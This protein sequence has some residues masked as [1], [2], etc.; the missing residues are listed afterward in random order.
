MGTFRSR[1]TTQELKEV[2]SLA[3]L[4]FI[5]QWCACMVFILRVVSS[6]PM[7]LWFELPYNAVGVRTHFALI[8]SRTRHDGYSL[9][10]FREL[11][12]RYA[13]LFTNS[14]LQLVG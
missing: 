8:K 9:N 10:F 7:I 14:I 3:Y 2:R 5:F 12:L 1:S 6:R 4:S 11:A 13:R